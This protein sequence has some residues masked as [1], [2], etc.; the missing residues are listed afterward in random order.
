MKD[1]K[2][3]QEAIFQ[4]IARMG[5]A[6]SSPHRLKILSLLSQGPK[7]VEQLAGLLDQS[8][9]AASANLKVLRS[10]GLV[11][12]TKSGR[13]VHC[14]LASGTVEG[15]WLFLRNLGEELLP[16]VR[17]VV[18]D[19]FSDPDSLSPLSEEELRREIEADR[20]VLFD[21]RPED[22]FAAG[23]LTG[24]RHLPFAA[25][26]TEPPSFPK[27]QTVLAYC[28]GPYCLMAISGTARL[29]AMGLDIKRLRFGVP[30]WRQHGFNLEITNTHP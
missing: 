21:L 6:L 12:G 1:L 3:Q 17:E 13:H 27:N 23:H 30:E 9:A 22:E 26:G 7:T 8:I 24:A 25:I 19:Y 2:S 11:I 18:R 10:S 20:V 29:K 5:Q 15:L 16:E 4:N 28:R 14:E